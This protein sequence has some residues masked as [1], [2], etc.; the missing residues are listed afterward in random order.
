VS[1]SVRK[2][3]IDDV[4]S[5]LRRGGDIR[6]L[7]SPR[8]VGATSGF[9]GVATLDPGDT[10]GQHYHP[11]SE[12]FLFVVR[13]C[14]LLRVDDDPELTIAANECVMVPRGARHSLRNTGTEPAFAVFQAAPL[15]PRPDLGHVDIAPARADRPLPQVGGPDV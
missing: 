6:V 8:T 3:H 14:V 15:A 5:N 9:M 12:E 10:I 1:G 13:G 2:V 11:F 4:P 7:L